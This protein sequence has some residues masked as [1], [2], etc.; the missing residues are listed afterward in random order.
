[1]STTSA[2]SL[3]VVDDE[4]D[5]R[6]LYELTLVRE[7]Y[8]VET[9]GTVE[10][11]W[12]H[13]AER[14]FSAVITDMRLPDG[15]GLEL[16]QR[17]EAEGRAEKAIVI[18]AYGS[19][20]G[21]VEAL[22][23]G[24]YDY[25]TKPVD[26]RQFRAVVASALGRALPDAHDCAAP[27][28][29]RRAARAGS[30]AGRGQGR[31]AT[32]GRAQRSD[33]AGAFDDRQ[34]GAQHGA[35]AGAGR[36]GHRQGT[37]GA[38]HP[39]GLV[40]CRAAVHRRQLR[41]H[42]R[43]PAGK[44]VLRLSQGRFH[45]RRRRPRRC[46]PGRP[47]R[48]AVPGRDRRAAAVDAE[49]AAACDSGARGAADRRGR[50]KPGQR[51]HRQRHAPRPRRRSAGLALPAGPLL[52]AQRDPDPA[53]AAARE[54]RRPGRD[55]GRRAAAHCRRGGRRAGARAGRRRAAS[56]RHAGLCR[57]CARAREPAA[58]RAGDV[59]RRGHRGA[60]P[61]PGRR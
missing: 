34:G 51:A 60:R 15:T 10:E 36:I 17:L 46:L 58:A 49:Q 50:R 20:Q 55:R 1:M 27:K 59:G 41:R 45:R 23:C 31:A 43:E 48:H 13:L 8:E 56:A 33:A 52:P 37:G 6:T 9:A 2:N 3:L 7:G 5:L 12:A 61:G 26:L 24:A 11:A 19:A 42:P 4:P 53:A 18:T 35:G 44:R 29:P 40:A 47:R 57:Q 14:P 22:K 16:L 30:A 39:R 21:A 28:R 38:R 54:A 32:A 25:L